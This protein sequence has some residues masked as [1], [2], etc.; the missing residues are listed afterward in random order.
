MSS[1]GHR[2]EPALP[3]ACAAARKLI[4]AFVDNEISHGQDARLR[5]H[6]K[7]CAACH[8]EYVELVDSV[9]SIHS[10]LKSIRELD[11]AERAS[12]VETRVPPED[13]PEPAR[14]R[15]FLARGRS[16]RMLRGSGIVIAL[17]A[18]VVLVA[19]CWPEQPV[20]SLT[21]RSTGGRI[22]IGNG[23]MVD[24]GEQIEWVRGQWCDV[25][26]G[27]T[28]ELLGPHG[29]IAADGP[30]LVLLESPDP[31]RVRVQKGELRVQ[32][33]VVVTHEHAVVEF[34]GARARA[35]VIGAILEIACE[36]GSAVIRSSN[37][38]TEIEAGQ[39]ARVAADGTL[40]LG[41]AANR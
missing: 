33:D 11:H 18:A 3:E 1:D 9:A 38:S 19:V 15:S 14:P 25:R 5:M 30:A 39:S 21:A 34:A 27:S 2:P 4:R 17:A 13:A 20:R 6:L 32:G 36:G 41:R 7:A 10:Q 29:E 12:G 35:R 28:A 40:E 8:A 31:M 22:S 37:G 24:S 23:A 26:V 16:Q